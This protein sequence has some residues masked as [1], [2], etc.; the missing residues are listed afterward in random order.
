[1]E[2]NILACTFSD[3][4]RSLLLKKHLQGRLHY[5]HMT[6]DNKNKSQQRWPWT[7]TA[8]WKIHN[9][10]NWSQTQTLVRKPIN[11]VTCWLA[12]TTMEV[13]F[14]EWWLNR[15]H[16]ALGKER[17]VTHFFLNDQ[18]IFVKKHV[19]LPVTTAFKYVRTSITQLQTTITED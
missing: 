5:T 15:H 2:W 9:E 1:M 17:V 16:L 18:L 14:W 13:C 10:S 8:R 7:M 4:Q 11:L 12:Q 3:R 6:R 19:F